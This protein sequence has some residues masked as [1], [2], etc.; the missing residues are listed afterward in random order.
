M[1]QLF[2]TVIEGGMV[3]SFEPDELTVRNIGIRGGRIE[4]VTAAP[5]IGKKRISAAGKIVA[6]GFIDF[7]SHVD[8]KEFSAECLLRQG[9][10]TTIGGERNLQ[11]NVIRRI[12]ENGFLINH[13]FRISHSFTLRQAAGINDP[14]RS[15]TVNE[16]QTMVRL[17]RLSTP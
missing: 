11:G 1:R 3:C 7:H 6:P 10:T 9:A 17:Y 5:L 8:G 2:D 16:I 4:E 13:G 12:D 14:Y 15:G